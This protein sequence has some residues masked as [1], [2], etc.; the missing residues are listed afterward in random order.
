MLE[1]ILMSWKTDN[2]FEL[3]NLRMDMEVRAPCCHSLKIFKYNFPFSVSVPRDDLLSAPRCFP[4]IG[5][6]S[7]FLG[8]KSSVLGG[9]GLDAVGFGFRRVLRRFFFLFFSDPF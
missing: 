8:V 6:G 1:A 2:A 7:T 9:A 4:L 3:E 5:T